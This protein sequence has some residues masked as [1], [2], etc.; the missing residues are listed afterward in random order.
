MITNNAYLDGITH[1]QMRRSLITQFGSAT[2]VDLHGNARKAEFAA[3]GKADENVF[4]IMQG[5]AVC[6]LAR[7]SI[8]SEPLVRV[9]HVQGTRE[10]KYSVLT[11]GHSSALTFSKCVPHEPYFL[12]Q[13]RS[14]LS[15]E[16][17]AG[18]PVSEVFQTY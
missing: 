16:Y 9:A 13:L 6:I 18:V 3:S 8:I 12:F 17:M 14:N 7:G 1:R 15:E 10:E 11:G 5:V 2:V 4:D